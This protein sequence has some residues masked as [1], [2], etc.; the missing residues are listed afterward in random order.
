MKKKN[1]IKTALLSSALLLGTGYAV[2]NNRVLTATGTVPIAEKE[3]DVRITSITGI[4][5]ATIAPDGLTAELTFEKVEVGFLDGGSGAT[6]NFTVEIT[7]YENDLTV[8]IFKV[9]AIV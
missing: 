5:N 7:N 8:E 9:S 2:I 4:P 3:L 1:L 6:N